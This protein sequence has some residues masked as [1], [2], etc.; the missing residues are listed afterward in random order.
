MEAQF[1]ASILCGCGAI[2]Q[3]CVKLII[4]VEMIE[5]IDLRWSKKI[6]STTDCPQKKLMAGW[7]SNNCKSGL[8]VYGHNVAENYAFGTPSKKLC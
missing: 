8:H 4:V 7:V 6:R 2:L 1:E 3:N 5:N